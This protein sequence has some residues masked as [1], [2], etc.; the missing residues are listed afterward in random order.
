MMRMLQES[1]KMLKM[2]HKQ[3]DLVHKEEMVVDYPDKKEKSNR[4]EDMPKISSNTRDSSHY[5]ST[6]KTTKIL[7]NFRQLN[8]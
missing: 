6:R 5:S 3:E 4:E 2:S 7:M 1:Y 8:A